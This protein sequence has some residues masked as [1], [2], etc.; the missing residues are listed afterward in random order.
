MQDSEAQDS[1]ATLLR[2]L[3]AACP[4]VSPSGRADWPGAEG[5]Y[6][7]LAAAGG[8][9]GAD[10]EVSNGYL[11]LEQLVTAYRSS[12]GADFYVETGTDGSYSGCAP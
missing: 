7:D 9:A 4:A 5:A 3:R 1:L 6:N 10:C 2:G 11:L 8:L 12:P